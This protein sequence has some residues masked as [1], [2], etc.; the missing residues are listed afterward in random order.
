[1]HK[2]GWHVN[3]AGMQAHWHVDHVDTQVHMI[4]DLAN[5][6]LFHK[7]NLGL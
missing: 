1:M 5:S 3:H 4:H 2:P 7:K 6:I